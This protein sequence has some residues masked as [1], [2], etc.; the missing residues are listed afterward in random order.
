MINKLMEGINELHNENQE[1]QAEV[2]RPSSLVPVFLFVT[3]HVHL[4]RSSN[5]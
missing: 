5:A 3:L 2:R 4:L 1:K